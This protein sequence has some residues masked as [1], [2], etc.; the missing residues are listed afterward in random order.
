MWQRKQT[1]FL[2]GSLIAV[3]LCLFFPIGAVST[4]TLD[5]QVLF[6][7][8]GWTSGG[9]VPTITA[10]PL[11]AIITIVGIISIVTI[12]LFSNRKLQMRLCA[13]GILLDIVWYAYFMYLFLIISSQTQLHFKFSVVMPL[14]SLI[15]LVLARKGIKA[16]EELVRSMDRIR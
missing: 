12:F 3:L 16:D 7:T 13:L 11:F 5:S 15:F 14:I 10:W 4:G 9:V 2:L 8:L 1:L 6:T